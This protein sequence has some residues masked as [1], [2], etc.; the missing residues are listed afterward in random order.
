[1][2]PSSVVDKVL[3]LLTGGF[4]EGPTLLRLFRS[5][6]EKWHMPKLGLY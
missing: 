5:S 4:E 1:M 2:E 6:K 3:F